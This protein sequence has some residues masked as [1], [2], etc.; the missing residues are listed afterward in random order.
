MSKKNDQE[1]L[2][3][4]PL[5]PQDAGAQRSVVPRI[6]G[7][8][9]GAMAGRVA[10]RALRPA[11]ARAARRFGLPAQPM[12]RIIEVAAPVAISIAAAQ[13]AKRRASRSGKAAGGEPAALPLV[14]HQQPA[15]L[16]RS[17]VS[18]R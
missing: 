1:V 2:E 3:G 18:G 13:F 15:A 12:M 17:E 10:A 5:S 11:A 8:V 4:M 14:P 7:G 9:A 16:G 6:G